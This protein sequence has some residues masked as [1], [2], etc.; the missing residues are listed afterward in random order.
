LQDQ[1]A[2]PTYN[3]AGVLTAIMANSSPAMAFVIDSTDGISFPVYPVT[4][5][6]V[7]FNVT[8]LVTSTTY[9]V[10]VSTATGDVPTGI[11]VAYANQ[12]VATT[13]PTMQTSSNGGV[14]WTPVTGDYVPIRA[15]SGTNGRPVHTIGD[16]GAGLYS[17]W[18]WL[19]TDWAG[20]VQA[21][22]EYA[23]NVRSWR[24]FSYDSF[25]TLISLT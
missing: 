21:L 13:Y 19:I 6:S 2:Y 22:G 7:P 16:A 25:G 20:K 10:V 15:F 11:C 5:V 17:P 8:G 24:N 9:H 14:T 23:S 3:N 18:T 1:L 4:I 12:G